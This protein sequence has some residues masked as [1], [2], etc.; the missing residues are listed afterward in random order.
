M[1]FHNPWVL[2]LLAALPFLATG[3]RKTAALSFPSGNLV[4]KLPLTPRILLYRSLIF[5]RVAG[6]ALLIFALARPQMPLGKERAVKEGVDIVLALD[7]STSMEALDF[8]IG[9]QR[10][11][12]LAVVKKV[13]DDFIQMRGND[14]LG[15]VAFAGRPYLVCP[16]TLDHD[17]VRTNV[18]RVQIGMVEDG[19]AIGSG[20]LAALNRLRQSTAK[21]KMMIVLTDGRN[22]AGKIA[23][24]DAAQ[25]A[26]ALGVKIY[27]IGAGSRGPVPYPAKNVFGQ[28]VYQHVE[29]DLDETSLQKIA[30]ITGGKYFR[31]TD[32]ESL[33]NIYREIDRLE[34][35]PFQQPQ[36]YRFRELCEIFISIA[37]LVLLIEQL[38]AGVV[39]VKIP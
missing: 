21:S 23:P 27:T 37:V 7:V 25:A 19:T 17:W 3:Q 18:E 34:K 39:T 11:N 30:E 33:K 22:N 26:R 8:K 35:T 24:A 28:T 38:L 36:F 29:V 9:G 15:I 13:V 32:T 4:R 14:R 10:Y 16:L 20:I 1:M 2:L 6:L 12:R 31:A 5:F